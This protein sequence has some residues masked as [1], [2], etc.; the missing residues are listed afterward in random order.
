MGHRL[1]WVRRRGLER[2]DEQGLRHMRR[3]R[4][5]RGSEGVEEMNKPV[6]VPQLG[7][8]QRK[9]LENRL[10][11]DCVYEYEDGPNKFSVTVSQLSFTR[12]CELCDLIREWMK[13]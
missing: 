3:D 8:E 2:E 9:V 5:R 7:A 10:P 1:R 12:M 11:V 13:A 4:M 6:L